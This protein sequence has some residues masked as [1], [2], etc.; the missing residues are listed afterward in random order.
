MTKLNRRGKVTIAV[1]TVASIGVMNAFT[2]CYDLKKQNE[3]L[4]EENQNLHI[5]V[6]NMLNELE[7]VNGQNETL[8]MELEELKKWTSLGEF[9]ITHY[10]PCYECSEGWGSQT[11][12]GVK[13]KAN[14]TIAVDPDVIPLGSEVKI[15]GKVYIAEDVG[16]YIYNNRIDIY[17]DNHQETVEKG[18]K[19]YEVAIKRRS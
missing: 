10:C 13:A 17:V 1:I 5:E 19:H 4:I 6:A 7:T 18:V 12:S 2:Y 16:G 15:N 9:R 14:R 11:A 3:L 8:E